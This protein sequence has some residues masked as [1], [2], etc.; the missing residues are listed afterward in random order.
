MMFLC[1][2][3]L[4]ND[5]TKI[6]LFLCER[7]FRSSL[8]FRIGYFMCFA[9]SNFLLLGQASFSSSKVAFK[10]GLITFLKFDQA[11]AIVRFV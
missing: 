9:R 1:Q 6:T 11:K 8:F 10:T 7:N 5:N 3:K 2:A 4:Q